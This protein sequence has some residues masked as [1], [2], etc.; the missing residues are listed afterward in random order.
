MVEAHALHDL[1]L[2]IDCL[3]LFHFDNTHVE[4]TRDVGYVDGHIVNNASWQIRLWKLTTI[5]AT[6]RP[7]VS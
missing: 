7:I 2:I 3:A 6:G 1:N 5:V 4:G